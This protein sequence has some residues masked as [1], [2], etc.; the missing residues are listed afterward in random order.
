MAAKIDYARTSSTESRLSWPRR[1]L[2]GLAI[3]T[4]TEAAWFSGVG[5]LVGW[6]GAPVAVLLVSA[7]YALCHKRSLR[8]DALWSAVAFSLLGLQVSTL[9]RLVLVLL[10]FF[11]HPL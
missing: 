1:I 6:W 10:P 3:G 7:V 4:A 9:V 2:P 11:T 8:F 5:G